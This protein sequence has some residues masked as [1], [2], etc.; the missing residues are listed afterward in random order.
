MV[1]LCSIVCGLLLYFACCKLIV[2]TNGGD[3]RQKLT[4]PSSRFSLQLPEPH[5]QTADRNVD[6]IRSVRIRNV[7]ALSRYSLHVLSKPVTVFARWNSAPLPAVS[8]RE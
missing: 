2:S 3:H 5:E 8:L 7:L 6:P 4:D 1:P